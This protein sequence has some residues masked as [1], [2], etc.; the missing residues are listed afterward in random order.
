MVKIRVAVLYNI[1]DSHSTKEVERN[2]LEMAKSVSKALGQKGNEVSLVNADENMLKNLKK[3]KP[4]IIFNL[5]ERFNGNPDLISHVAALLEMN[6]MPFTGASSACFT[7]CDDK[8]RVKELMQHYNIPTPKFQVFETGKEELEQFLAFPLIV[9]PSKTHDSIGITNDSVVRN[10]KQMRLKI[11]Q[12]LGDLKQNAIVEEYIDG[13]EF[14]I[15]VFGNQK[16]YTLPICE[17]DLSGS[18]SGILSY[19]MKWH[20]NWYREAPIICPVGLPQRVQEMLNQ[21][22]LNVHKKFRLRDYSRVDI[23]LGKNNV[24]YVLEIN[25][26]P[27]LT[28][29][30]F[31][32]HSAKAA[33]IEYQ[34]VISR[35][36]QHAA[37]RYGM[38]LAIKVASK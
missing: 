7:I 14:N 30:C 20:I 11:N 12:I 2:L 19:E 23:R 37:E 6:S 8:I 16:P 24:P 18:R 17:V 36:L 28:E 38:P 29:D 25:A 5:A 27:G 1:S 32:F 26:N 10:E 3:E 34:E 21:T 15:A 35:I 22:A 33:G 31:I 9:K 4:D 13:R